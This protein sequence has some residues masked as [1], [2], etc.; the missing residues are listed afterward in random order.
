MRP[1][2]LADPLCGSL[3]N[4]CASVVS[5]FPRDFTTEAQRNTEVHRERPRPNDDNP[6]LENIR[7]HN[8]CRADVI[9]WRRDR[10]VSGTQL[11]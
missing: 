5:V 4:L 9:H 1:A 11:P 10:P 8:M 3:C 2:A 7:G 6:K